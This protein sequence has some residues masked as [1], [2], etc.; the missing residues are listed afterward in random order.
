MQFNYYELFRA[1]HQRIQSERISSNLNA[2]QPF[3]RIHRDTILD[4]YMRIH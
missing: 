1:Y 2:P 3:F 4:E